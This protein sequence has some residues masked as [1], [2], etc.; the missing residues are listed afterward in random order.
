[1]PSDR[2]ELIQCPSALGGSL[3]RIFALGALPSFPGRAHLE[4]IFG[5]LGTVER[6]LGTLP[7][8]ASFQGPT[9]YG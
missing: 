9:V 3:E 4:E 6:Y 2:P 5:A 8:E 1:M 7:V